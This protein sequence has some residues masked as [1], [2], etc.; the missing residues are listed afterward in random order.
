M[1]DAG[2][3]LVLGGGFGGVFTALRLARRAPELALTLVARDPCFVFKPLL[4][5][6]LTGEVA[7]EE[8]ALPLAQVLAGS[9]IQLIEGEVVAIEPAARAAIV[10]TAAGE[11]RL[12]ADALVIA[13]GA[14]PAYRELP[15]MAAHALAAA[16]LEDFLR[17]RVHLERMSARAA[18]LGTGASASAR[19]AGG[20][21]VAEGGGTADAEGA[22]RP[23]EAERLRRVV[24]CGAG[25]SGVEIACKVAAMELAVRPRVLL[26][27]ARGDVLPGFS[28]EIKHQ[29]YLALRA[30]GVELRLGSP[31]LGADEHG[32]RL[33]G[34]HVPAGT[35]IWTAGQQ[36]V[37]VVRGLSVP[38][39]RD[40]R[41]CVG[42]TLEL[43]GQP[44]V[45][46][47]GDNAR[48]TIEG[49][50]APP[51]TAQV[52]VQQAA[53][54]AHNVLARL[55]GGT[56]RSYRYYPLAETLTLGRGQDVFHLLGL[57]LRGELGYLA[58][59]CVYLARM[60]SWRH[61]ARLAVR[62]GG[63]LVREAWRRAGRAVLAAAARDG[64][65]AAGAEQGQAGAR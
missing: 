50:E 14:E 53:V 18:A 16:T 3:V 43:P 42:A 28:E 27:E 34:E 37:G 4:Y 39:S 22:G 59:R 52:A 31:V 45:F 56:L 60:P 47:I 26:V 23:A 63:A 55:R 44:A 17:L 21:Q 13:L 19:I 48:C 41:I 33:P 36:P 11:Q 40:G 38:R 62:W 54:A 12:E 6:L 1:A 24:I 35:V 58:R 2:R 32:I 57:R 10:R 65:A 5:D 9:G 30:A 20:A 61:R 49:A 46:A 29:A 8:V 25:P 7:P 51:E 15:G 64:A